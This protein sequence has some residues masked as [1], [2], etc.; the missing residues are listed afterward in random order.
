ME[1]V[2]GWLLPKKRLAIALNS[3]NAVKAVEKQ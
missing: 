3:Q 1:N 2:V